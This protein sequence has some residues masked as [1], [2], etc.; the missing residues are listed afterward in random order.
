MQI[1]M[2]RIGTGQQRDD[3]S[4]WKEM[5]ASSVFTFAL[6]APR[7]GERDGDEDPTTQRSH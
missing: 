6:L 5:R 1:Q 4:G 2:K 7:A 3:N